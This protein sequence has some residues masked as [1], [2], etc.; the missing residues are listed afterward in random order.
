MRSSAVFWLS[1]ALLVAAPAQGEAVFDLDTLLARMASTRGVEARFREER[2][3]ALLVDPLVSRGTL[4]FVPPDRMA[5]FT[6]EPAPASLVVEGESLRFREGAEGPEL[7]LS[8][9]PV[10]HAFVENFMAVFSGDRARLEKL[11]Y[12]ELDGEFDLAGGLDGWQ[13]ALTPRRAPLSR[14]LEVVLLRGDAGG[15]REMEIRDADGDRTLTRF[16]FVD[17]DRSFSEA[18]LGRLFRDGAPLAPLP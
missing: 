7:D 17:H 10:A 1:A 4:Y 6:T 13:L 14:F 3:V 12:I 11:Y 9:S 5:R 2:F 18:E 16:E 8:A 15:M